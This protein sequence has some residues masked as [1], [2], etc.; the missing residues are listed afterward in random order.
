ML[1]LF[2]RGFWANWYKTYMFLQAQM[3]WPIIFWAHFIALGFPEDWVAKVYKIQDW[4]LNKF[5]IVKLQ[6]L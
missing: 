3:L 5:H 6:L 1:V 2:L 4:E